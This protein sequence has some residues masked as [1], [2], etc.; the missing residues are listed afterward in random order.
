M[1]ER[2]QVYVES[3]VPLA[4]KEEGKRR[5]GLEAEKEVGALAHAPHLNDS[6]EARKSCR[7]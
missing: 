4:G 1:R 5:L 2:G 3:L 6:G 7:A